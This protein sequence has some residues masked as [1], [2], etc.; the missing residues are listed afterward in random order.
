MEESLFPWQENNT[1]RRTLERINL[2]FINI[3]SDSFTIRQKAKRVNH[4]FKEK[5]R[6]HPQK[7]RNGPSL[8]INKEDKGSF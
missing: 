6:V 8:Y 7:K 4:N 5:G 2:F 1:K 3:S